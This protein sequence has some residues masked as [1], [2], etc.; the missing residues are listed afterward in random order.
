M[1]VSPS[2]PEPLHG[3]TPSLSPALPFMPALDGVRGAAMVVVLLYHSGYRWV[4]GGHLGVTSFFVLSGFLITGLMLC[5][6]EREGCIRLRAFWARRARRLAPGAVLGVAV[7]TAYLAWGAVLRPADVIGDAVA[8]LGWVA[9]W[10]FVLDG[11]TYADAV[12]GP[13]PFQH[14]WSL[15]VEEQLYLLLPLLVILC[16]GRG[17]RCRRWLLG[18]VVAVGII[19]STIAAAALHDAGAAPLRA[20]YGTDARVAEPLVGVLLALFLVGRHGLRRLGP[21]AVRVIDVLALAALG[22]LAL[23]FAELSTHDARLYDGGFLAAAIASAVVIAAASQPGTIT[24][25]LFKGAWLPSLGRISYGAYLFHWPI[26]LWLTPERTGLEPLPLLATRVS[27]TVALAALSHALIEHPIR[28]GLLPNRVALAGWATASV[29]VVAALAL[30]TTLVPANEVFIGNEAAAAPPPP[31]PAESQTAGAPVRAQSSAAGKVPRSSAKRPRSGSAPA[32][33]ATPTEIAPGPQVTTTTAPPPPPLRIAVL[34]DS[35]AANLGNGMEHWASGRDDVVVY[36]VGIPACPFSRGGVRRWPNTPAK[37]VA[38]V[39]GWWADPE[40]SWAKAVAQF[41]A[42]VVIVHDGINA[43]PDRYRNEWGS[44]Y[45]PGE[46]PFN[47][48]ITEEYRL[49]FEAVAPFG[50]RAI[51]LNT[52]CANWQKLSGW[53]TQIDADSRVLTMNGIIYQDVARRADVVIGDLHG[54]LCPNGRY[55]SEVEGVENGRPDGMHL[56][57]EASYRLAR[58]WLGP[59]AFEVADRY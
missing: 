2:E 40:S 12:A 3:T 59:M 45:R 18:S 39:C 52:P 21:L 42:D 56:S 1:T 46:P 32:P 23:L 43:I 7:A 28:V 13:S 9:N 34:G 38:E 19:G 50:E 14:Y 5:E 30:A 44:W 6:R 25:Q 26:F 58:R 20:Y 35:M 8:A 36:S 49:L 11:Q 53:E 37:S 47:E 55:S 33:A 57:D 48:W 17:E 51:L 54:E 15:A 41:D 16:L 27:V 4:V 22:G 29:A 31:P 24:G 10:R